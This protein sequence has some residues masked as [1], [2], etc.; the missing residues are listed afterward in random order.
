[1]N[2]L[3]ITKTGRISAS[4]F[5]A[6][7]PNL[8]V[9][10]FWVGPI[11]S[12]GRLV[13]GGLSRSLVIQIVFFTQYVASLSRSQGVRG[14]VL[15]LKTASVILMQRLPGGTLES[16]S[17][18][19]GKVGVSRS[20]DGLPR[21]IPR[22]ARRLIR[23]GHLP[24]IRLWVSLLG[25]YRI[26]TFVGEYKFSTI[27]SPGVNIDLLKPEWIAFVTNVFLPMVKHWYGEKLVGLDPA[28][29]LDKPKVTANVKTG[30]NSSPV[31]EIGRVQTGKTVRII[32][33]GALS[34]FGSRVHAARLWT[35][36]VWGSA[37][38]AYLYAIS[39]I[40][41]TR[42]LWSV[43]LRTAAT[44]QYSNE[45][46]RAYNIVEGYGFRPYNGRLAA[47]IEAAG[48]VR[49]FAL[50]DYWTQVVLRPLHLFIFSI[51]KEIP[52]DG[53][54]D[55][56][57]PL[58]LLLKEVKPGELIYSYDLSAATDRLSVWLQEAILGAIFNVSFAQAWR[59]LLVGRFYRLPAIPQRDLKKFRNSIGKASPHY[60]EKTNS[61]RYAVGQPIGA[62]SSWAMLALTHHALVQ[63]AAY[64]IGYKGWFPLY[65]I[66]GDD[67][68]IGDSKVAQSYLAVCK[69]IGL[70]IGLA[71]S[72]VSSNRTAEFAKR[73]FFNG[74][75]VS[76]IP[77]SFWVASQ[78]SIGVAIALI[79]RC[80]SQQ[81]MSL[82]NIVKAFGGSLRA[83][84]QTGNAWEAMSR[85]VIVLLV[86]L[87]HPSSQTSFA[88]KEWLEW[89]LQRGPSLAVEIGGEMSWFTPWATGLLEMVIRPAI[90]RLEDKAEAIFFGPSC[91]E[92][93]DFGH[94]SPEKEFGFLDETARLLD[95]EANS[96]LLKAGESL[97]K[98]E[99][100]LQHLQKLNIKFMHHQSSAVFNQLT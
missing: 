98:A 56:L 71:K 25:L 26:L 44:G 36:G 34:S 78:Q 58:R 57:A 67:I 42:S 61:V 33:A 22:F 77:H 89:L 63:Y 5:T 70:D 1:M 50:V 75:D 43:I 80:T 64:R 90:S 87:T 84:S 35:S 21:I 39:C 49:I 54:F 4:S 88:R 27:V 13:T 94:T 96:D 17:R 24:T 12:I 14:V 55:Q 31:E 73:L 48:K 7:R 19:I 40:G 53:T 28:I 95:S 82:A 92:A 46:Y 72:L 37:I 10:R 97:A 6:W 81:T 100:T 45:Y 68:V 99:A 2:C 66:L 60:D 85:R 20:G 11:L 93:D 62:L 29:K 8:K 38:E 52:Q 59:E 69:L 41:T 23:K 30:A 83:L 79:A 76:G 16:T 51:L 9:W 18:E 86:L 91:T 74:Q 47:K 3:R 32:R 15:Y 65:A